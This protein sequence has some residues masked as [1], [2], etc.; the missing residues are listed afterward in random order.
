MKRIIIVDNEPDMEYLFSKKFRKEIRSGS[1][2]FIFFISAIEALSYLACQENDS[3]DLI[4]SDINLP[5]I[6]GLEMLKKIKEKYKKIKVFMLTA[7]GYDEHYKIAQ[8]YGTDDYLIKPIDFEE[9][10]QKILDL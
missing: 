9:I 6:N 8:K 10:K 3:I 7:H 4:I 1:L 5:T 2:K